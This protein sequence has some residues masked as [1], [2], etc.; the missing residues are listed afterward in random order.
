MNP[1]GE[2]AT[3]KIVLTICGFSY[4]KLAVGE[5]PASELR[6]CSA[7]VGTS[8]NRRRLRTIGFLGQSS[9]ANI[10]H[11]TGRLTVLR[12]GSAF[13]DEFG[14]TVYGYAVVCLR[15]KNRGSHDR[16]VGYGRV[17][18]AR[19]DEIAEHVSILPESGTPLRRGCRRVVMRTFDYAV[20]Y[21]TRD[22]L[23]EVVAVLHCRLHPSVLA[24]RLATTTTHS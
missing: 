14:R 7:A 6:T 3:V 15:T 12:Q 23:I 4:G 10:R 2:S 11:S 13:C 8:S 20:V 22:D 19:L 24:T 16:R 5:V 17:F 18:V 1:S 9:T 21:R